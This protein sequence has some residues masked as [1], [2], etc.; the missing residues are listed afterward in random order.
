M[1]FLNVL[2]VVLGIVVFGGLLWWSLRLQNAA[3]K[4][5][6]AISFGLLA[7]LLALVTILA[8]VGDARLSAKPGNPVSQLPVAGSPDQIA[9]GQSLVH[10][11]ARCHS[12]SNGVPLDGGAGSF[13]AALFGNMVPP[14]LTPGGPLKSW[15]DGE[16]IRAIREGIG[17]N[18]SPLLVMPSGS[19]RKLSDADVEAIVAYLRSQP[20]VDR[21]TPANNLN[22]FGAALVGAGALPTSA[23]P[24][25]V[26]P[27]VMPAG[28][29][30][31]YG[32]YLVDVIGCRTCHGADLAG[33]QA[34]G[35]NP[36]GPNLTKLVPTWTEAG[37]IQTLR[38]GVDPTGYPL[39]SLMPWK[40][41]GG[42]AD[43]DLKAIYA[44]LHGL[45][46]INR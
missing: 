31:E 28:V 17:Q 29:T 45:T 16:I 11:C 3:L 32:Q 2:P 22:V 27:S 35:P 43:D 40:S 42:F 33:G 15:S 12:S 26:E 9:R 38:T 18:G 19:F 24:P 14:N 1:L 7:L 23:Q 30:P 25:V 37:F 13:V 41:F 20:A 6:G 36:D 46:P 34:G 44:Y 39:N 21:A 10:M 5:I 8:L 4:W